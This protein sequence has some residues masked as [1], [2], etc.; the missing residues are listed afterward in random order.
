MNTSRSIRHRV[1][2]SRRQRI[3]NTAHLSS[4]MKSLLFPKIIS[5]IPR[6]RRRVTTR[7]L[8]LEPGSF[9]EDLK[10]QLKCVTQFDEHQYEALSYFWGKAPG[11]II[12]SSSGKRIQITANCEA[13]L[14]RIRHGTEPRFLWVDAICTDQSND[15]ERSRQVEIMQNIYTGAKRVI[16]WLGETSAQDSLAL[17]SLKHLRKQV[18][19]LNHLRLSARLGWFRDKRVRKSSPAELISLSYVRLPMN[20]WETCFIENG[21]VAHGLFKKLPVRRMQ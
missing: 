15:N 20:I 7:L 3:E 1:N 13:A 17:S 11:T 21:S 9:Q 2:Y 6:W 16:I 19:T 5:H 10:C 4:R 8:I 12:E 18:D 14:R